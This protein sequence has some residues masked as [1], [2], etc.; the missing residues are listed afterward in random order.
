[1]K[2]KICLLSAAILYCGLFIA[3]GQPT[4]APASDT[5]QNNFATTAGSWFTSIDMT[6]SYPTNGIAFSVGALWENN[7]NWCNYLD[8]SK[9]FGK[10]V[11]NGEMGNA[12]VAGTIERGQLGIGYE[13]F[14]QGDA[15]LIAS[16]S[17][18]Y[19][20]DTAA[21]ET[22]GHGTYVQPMLTAQKIMAHGS[23]AEIG[24][25]YDVYVKGKQPNSPLLK[26]GAGFT[27]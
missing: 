17:P 6:K 13:A 18:G 8:V 9:N 14:R 25:G 21:S 10:V 5:A 4:N 27:F 22:V 20:R 7:V 16:V 3:Q 19:Q 2:T 23:F 1:M 24:I 26:V 11:V 15:R 12:G